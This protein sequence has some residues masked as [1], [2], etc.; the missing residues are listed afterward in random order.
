[1]DKRIHIITGHYGSGKSEI[2]VNMAMAM[3]Q[4]GKKV[5]FADLDIIN[6]YFRS[7]EARSMLEEK[8]VNV[9]TTQYANS[10]VDIPALTGD[11]S[12]YLP[13]ATTCLV[14]DVGGDDA[15]SRVIGRYRDE[16]PLQDTNLYF[17]VNCFRPETNSMDGTMKILD[18]VRSASRLSVNFLINNANL[19]DSTTMK[20]ILTGRDFI[21][22][23]SR[24]TGIPI[25]FHAIMKGIQE[26]NEIQLNEPIL[27]MEKTM[28]FT[29]L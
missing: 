12:R 29:N 17:V 5:I 18:E 20:D 11:L 4:K 7:N 22:E 13:D 19:L 14:I 28:G 26:S 25:A 24:A 27:W 9:I 1:M 8:G 2:S 23:A 10:N 16:I 6:P 21:L 3:A 15:G